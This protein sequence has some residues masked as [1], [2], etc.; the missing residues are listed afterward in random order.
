MQE[1]AHTAFSFLNNNSSKLDLDVTDFKD[2]NYHIHIPAGATPKEGPSA[3]IALALL[4]YS[5]ISGKPCRP[6]WALTGEITLHGKAMS[7]GGVKEKILAAQQESFEGVMLPK[8]N[9]PQI[10]DLETQAWISLEVRYIDN[11]WDA[12]RWLFP[13]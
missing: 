3:G 5:C 12:L 8:S 10:E 6:F 11:F 2:F 13:N 9:Q 4:L 1:S 7:I